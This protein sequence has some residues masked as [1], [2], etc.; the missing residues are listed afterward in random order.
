M[1]NREYPLNSTQVILCVLLYSGKESYVPKIE[2]DTESAITT[3]INT[4]FGEDVKRTTKEKYNLAAEIGEAVIR[5]YPS[6]IES[7]RGLRLIEINTFLEENKNLTFDLEKPTKS[8]DK[9]NTIDLSS[10]SV[11][12]C[13]LLYIDFGEFIHIIEKP[14]EDPMVIAV[15]KFY[16]DDKTR[17]MMDEYDLAL[18][19]AEAAI[20][21]HPSIIKFTRGLR[22][23]EINTFL[24]EN[25][26]LTFEL[27]KPTKPVESLT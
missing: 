14:T 24:E 6:I 21:Q 26:N 25:K 4:V 10:I 11:I 27:E 18:K 13:I 23:R 16:G 9:I 1:E 3:A 12:T 5:Q 19:I 8:M 20:M 17:S 22:L 2:D 15:K 7:T